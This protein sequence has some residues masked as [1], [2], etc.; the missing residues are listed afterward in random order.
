MFNLIT[1]IK[2][3]MKKIVTILIL[4]ATILAGGMTID[5]K[6]TKKKAKAKAKTSKTSSAS[7]NWNGENPNGVQIC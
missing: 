6:T 7:K 4:V 1:K 2:I 3:I 5:A